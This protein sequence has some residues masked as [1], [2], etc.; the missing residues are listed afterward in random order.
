MLIADN[1]I[2]NVIMVKWSK[3]IAM[4]PSEWF[5]MQH[6]SETESIRV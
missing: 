3:A 2:G 1:Q 5:A 4:E 6:S